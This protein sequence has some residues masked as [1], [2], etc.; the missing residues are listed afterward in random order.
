MAIA[1]TFQIRVLADIVI[2]LIAIVIIW[3]IISLP[4]YFSAKV[5]TGGKAS[6][7]AAMGATLLGPI[8]YVLTFIATSVLL[9]ILLGGGVGLLALIFAFLAWLAVYKAA[10]ATG[11]LGALAITV[12]S[13]IIYLVLAVL[14]TSFFEPGRFLNP[15]GPHGGQF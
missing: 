4:V 11:W 10:F 6:L 8:V 2:I 14:L 9:R 3:I 15:F 1:T 12:I 5:V 7:G 13:V